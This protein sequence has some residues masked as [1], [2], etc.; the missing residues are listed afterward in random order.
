VE[1]DGFLLIGKIVG[2]HGLRG[3]LKVYSYAEYPSV[4]N[5]GGL[6]YL[7]SG[8]GRKK[9]HTI[10]WAKPHRKGVLLTFKG[11]DS[12]TDA[13]PLI[14]AELLINKKSLPKLEK[15]TYYWFDIVGLSVYTAD[16]AYIGRVT[17]IMPTGSNDVYVVQDEDKEI[18]VPA[19][20]S[21]ITDID[22]MGKRMTVD[23]PE[24]L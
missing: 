23:L 17:S 1:T 2:A 18:L 3:A 20:E 11:I 21:V 9:T 12:R 7:E 6:I 14:G 16:N 22:F 15:G 4:F 10:T 5:P 8:R 24:G 19:L 13:E